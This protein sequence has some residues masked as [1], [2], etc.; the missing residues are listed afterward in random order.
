MQNRCSKKL[1]IH[2]HNGSRNEL[3][4][5]KISLLRRPLA[6]DSVI[7]GLLE[8]CQNIMF[9]WYLSGGSKSRKVGPRCG[10]RG[11]LGTKTGARV[12]DFQEPR[13]PG[14][15]PKYTHAS[16]ERRGRQKERRT[17]KERVRHVEK[18]TK[19]FEHAS[20]QRPGELLSPRVRWNF[21][22]G[23]TELLFGYDGTSPR[24]RCNSSSCAMELLHVLFMGRVPRH[25]GD[26]S[27]C[28]TAVR[29][30]DVGALGQ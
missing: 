11:T 9:F 7:F 1:E 23:T 24:V 2:C 10:Q 3:K 22:W 28:A 15:G 18:D 26:G 17:K 27:K 4:S 21:S 8:L 12:V 30:H 16:K 5:F 14:G 20:G 29:A 6:S 19:G 13:P 25:R